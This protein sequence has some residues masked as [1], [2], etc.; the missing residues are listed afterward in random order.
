MADHHFLVAHLG[1]ARLEA[2]GGAELDDDMRPDLEERKIDRVVNQKHR[3]RRE[4][5]VQHP[6]RRAI[7]H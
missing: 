1:L 4:H 3:Q 2:F 7:V 5:P 6:W